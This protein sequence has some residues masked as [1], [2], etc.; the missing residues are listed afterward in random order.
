[1]MVIA[2]THTL[3]GQNLISKLN[4]ENFNY[5]ILV[6]ENESP[7]QEHSK[8][9][10]WHYVQEVHL[11]NWLAENAE[12]IEFVF[13]CKID[14]LL[15]KNSLFT[16]I[17]QQCHQHQIPLIFS[18]SDPSMESWIQEQPQP[19]FWA[20]LQ[21]SAIYGLPPKSI[22]GEQLTED[23]LIERLTTSIQYPVNQLNK[24]TYMLTFVQDMVD[25]IYFFIRHRQHAGCYE[26]PCHHTDVLPFKSLAQQ[27]LRNEAS[28]P[29]MP[30]SA[31]S[32]SAFAAL[33]TIGY[34]KQFCSLPEGIDQL[35]KNYLA[36]DRYI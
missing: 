21:V 26:M 15:S 32:L 28:P 3:L 8:I 34:D 31:Q 13:W 2:G 24:N 22:S 11:S 9:R 19:F 30:W 12:E 23:Q 14:V 33:Q 4:E 1:M 10:Y 29:P 35:V 18:S 6:D 25:V 20:G 16:D 7:P 17:W 27:V 36:S 5:L